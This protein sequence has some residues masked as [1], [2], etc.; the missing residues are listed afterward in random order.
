MISVNLMRQ[1]DGKHVNISFN[2]GE[3]FK[4]IKCTNFYRKEDDDEENMLEFGNIIVFQSEIK[5][6]EL[7]T[8]K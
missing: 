1:A 4:D 8:V 7:V 6:I 3:C 5:N 2:D